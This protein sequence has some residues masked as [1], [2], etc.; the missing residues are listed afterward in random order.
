MNRITSDI[1]SVPGAENAFGFATK[2]G[3]RIKVK[4]ARMFLTDSEIVGT[5]D[6]GLSVNKHS[7]P[8]FDGWANIPTDFDES[9]Y[10]NIVLKDDDGSYKNIDTSTYRETDQ[11]GR[12]L[13]EIPKDERKRIERSKWLK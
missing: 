10:P 7:V 1:Q 2:D 6:D 3:E 11:F 5:N 8:V 13:S 4:D 9:K 12:A